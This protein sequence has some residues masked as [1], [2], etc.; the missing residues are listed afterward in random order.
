M[1]IGSQTL[2]TQIV[3]LFGLP[4]PKYQRSFNVT[5]K[6]LVEV[7]I[8]IIPTE[9]IREHFQLD[10]KK[11]KVLRLSPVDAISLASYKDNLIAQ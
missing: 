9:N 10:G 1:V 8:E 7:D 5:L 6:H 3:S 2:K 4:C 11:L